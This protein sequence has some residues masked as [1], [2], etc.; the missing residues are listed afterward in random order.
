MLTKMLSES[1]VLDDRTLPE[2][3][4]LMKLASTFQN[5]TK[6]LFMEPE[7]LVEETGIGT[8]EQWNEILRFQETQNFIK[9]QMAFISQIAQR[10]TFSSLVQSA[11]G[12]NAQAAKQV[13]RTYS[14]GIMYESCIVHKNGGT[15]WI[16]N[17][18]MC[19]Q[20]T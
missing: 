12:G 14:G 11:L 13:Q 19:D 2:K 16:L 15:Q 3:T 1:G 4:I 9:G 20:R 6:L 5:N 8:K 10:K 17:Y 7:E 18:S